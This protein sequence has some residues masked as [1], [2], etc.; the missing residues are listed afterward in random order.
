MDYS[1][2][3]HLIMHDLTLDRGSRFTRVIAV[4]LKASNEKAESL[5]AD[6]FNTCGYSNVFISRCYAKEVDTGLLEIFKFDDTR[7][8]LFTAGQPR[9]NPAHFYFQG[10]A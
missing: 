1:E 4:R 5:I 9:P 2:F 7:P 3:G 8:P 10:G 6:F